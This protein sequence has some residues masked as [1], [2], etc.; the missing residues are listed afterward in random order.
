MSS[1][2]FTVDIG[3]SNSDSPLELNGMILKLV[4]I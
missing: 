4:K 2:K 1:L 3:D